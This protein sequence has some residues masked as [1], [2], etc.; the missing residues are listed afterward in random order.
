MGALVVVAFLSFILV[1][2]IPAILYY[3]QG[4]LVQKMLP[5]I[6]IQLY[7]MAMS[8]LYIDSN[9]PYSS[10]SLLIGAVIIFFIIATPIVKLKNFNIARI[11]T[12]LTTTFSFLFLYF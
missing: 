9:L 3:K 2:G 1:L 5:F 8:I 11:M 10:S 12:V 6:L 4:K 7:P